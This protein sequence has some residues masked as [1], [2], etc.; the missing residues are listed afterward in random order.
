MS[1]TL[2]IGDIHGCLECFER[3]LSLVK[4]HPEDR[5]ISV[6][7]L[8]HRGPDSARVVRRMREI[9]AELVIGV[10]DHPKTYL[11]EPSPE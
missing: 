6:G 9:N 3:L 2:V 10:I 5:V 8:I 4:I 1:R 11:F 7:D